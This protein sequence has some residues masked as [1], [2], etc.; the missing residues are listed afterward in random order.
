MSAP[1]T[2][3]APDTPV[4]EAAVLLSRRGIAAMPVLD[5]DGC[6]AGIVSETDLMT[7]EAAEPDATVARLMTREVV[8]VPSGTRVA[9]L[10]ALL[11]RVGVRSLPVVSAERRV[12][13]MVA[14][15]DVA[16]AIVH[17]DNALVRQVRY[18]L[19]GYF[20][21][22][23]RWDVEADRGLVT[24]TGEF[25][26]EAEPQMVHAMAEI[27]PGVKWVRV[28]ARNTVSCAGAV[29]IPRLST[30]ADQSCDGRHPGTAVVAG[31]AAG[32]GEAPR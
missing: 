12:L 22:G 23:R 5:G 32:F 19:D 11:V 3:V 27:V 18:R 6:L 29:P 25:R 7:E 26:D 30:V 28:V 2:C 31:N 20:G 21:E 16:R 15:R 17:R 24:V 4:S 13:G 14:R 8:S 10:P 1:V 9:E